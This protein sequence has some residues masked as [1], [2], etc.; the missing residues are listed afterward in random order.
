MRELGLKGLLAPDS[1]RGIYSAMNQIVFFT[2]GEDE[3]RAWS[4][5]R[6]ENAVAGAAQIHT[7]LAKGFV[8]AEVVGRHTD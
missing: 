3:C 7:D 8:R 1:L 4:L 2:V 5:A 6:G